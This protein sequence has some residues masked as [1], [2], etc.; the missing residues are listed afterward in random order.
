MAEEA[1]AR[2]EE[3]TPDLDFGPPMTLV[4]PKKTETIYALSRI[5]VASSEQ[6]INCNSNNKKHNN[7]NNKRNNLNKNIMKEHQQ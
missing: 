3:E 1:T 7:L 6:N 5:H 2:K 4:R